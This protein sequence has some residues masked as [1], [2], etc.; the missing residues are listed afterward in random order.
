MD[1]MPF[2]FSGTPQFCIFRFE[3]FIPLRVMRAGRPYPEVTAAFLLNSLGSFH[4]FALV[5]STRPPV[6][7]FGTV[8]LIFKSLEA[9]LGRMLL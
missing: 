3:F 4:P 7:V 5:Y 8:S 2:R 9:F 6:S 1:K